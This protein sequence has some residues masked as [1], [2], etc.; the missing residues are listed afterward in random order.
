M[1]RK[2]KGREVWIRVVGLPLH[3][4]ARE[5][6]QRIRHSCGGLLEIDLERNLR[7]EFRWAT[8]RV[9]RE[10]KEGSNKIN[11]LDGLRSYE[12]FSWHEKSFL[13]LCFLDYRK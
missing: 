7:T 13:R 1:R 12:H 2:Q 6:I 5:I 10:E 11:I 8:L 3:L 4:S 9:K